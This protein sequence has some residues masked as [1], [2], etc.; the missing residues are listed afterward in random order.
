[1]S[2]LSKE[3]VNKKLQDGKIERAQSKAEKEAEQ[4]A[5]MQIGRKKKGGEKKKKT[6]MVQEAFNIDINTI[7]KFGFLKVSP[8]LGAESLDDKIKEL[9]GK[10]TA[11]IKEGDEKLKAEEEMLEEGKL[12]EL[13]EEE[14]V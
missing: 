14:G 3:E 7:N 13:E 4:I 1:M 12:E 11:Y 5:A 10:L 2:Q 6:V 8:P 9:N